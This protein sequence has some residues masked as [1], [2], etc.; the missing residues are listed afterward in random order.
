M[1]TQNTYPEL[2]LRIESLDAL[3]DQTVSHLDNT[4]SWFWVVVFGVFTII[5]IA[6][7]F[8]A[9]NLIK[10]GI[11]NATASANKK[12]SNLQIELDA[13]KDSLAGF[14]YLKDGYRM[15][16]GEREYIVPPMKPNTV[17]RTSEKYLGEQPVYT[18]LMDCGHLPLSSTTKIT[19]A[20]PAADVLLRS[21]LICADSGCID[22]F[23]VQK[24]SGS[25]EITVSTK[26]C[27]F[28]ADNCPKFYVQLWYTKTD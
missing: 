15:V 6:L 7:Y 3:Y 18:I 24:I 1:R 14:E 22:S 25:T 16:D 4:I 27:D 17:Y 10:A 26:K 5:G 13:C 21:S 20:F 28:S 2:L 19:S 8:I 11:E 23:S 9:K 12:I